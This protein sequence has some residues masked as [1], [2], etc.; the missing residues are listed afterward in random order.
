METHIKGWLWFLLDVSMLIAGVFVGLK[1]SK[2]I[3]G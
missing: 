3:W 2:M 1:I